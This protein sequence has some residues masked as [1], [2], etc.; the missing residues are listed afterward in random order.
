MG[1]V[2]RVNSAGKVLIGEVGKQRLLTRIAILDSQRPNVVWSG[3][4]P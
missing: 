1:A 3:S 2:R 4:V